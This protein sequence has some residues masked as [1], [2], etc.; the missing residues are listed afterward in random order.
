MSTK[1]KHDELKLPEIAMSELPEGTK[2]FLICSS[3]SDKPV[4]EVIQDVLNKAASAA[5]F[6]IKP[7]AA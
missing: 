5:G 7:H 1:Q 4:K 3:A 6:I 2:D